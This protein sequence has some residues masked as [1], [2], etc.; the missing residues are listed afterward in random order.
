MK[1]HFVDFLA[2]SWTARNVENH[3]CVVFAAVEAVQGYRDLFV[4]TS[5][6]AAATSTSLRVN[7]DE[8]RRLSS[9]SSHSDASCNMDCSAASSFGNVILFFMIFILIATHHRRLVDVTVSL[10]A[11]SQDTTFLAMF[12]PGPC[13]KL[14]FYVLLR[15]RRILL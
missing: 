1:L 15:L 5:S 6:S 4:D 3:G 11:P 9:Q 8:P 2:D 14:L 12:R 10:Q 13:L 7:G